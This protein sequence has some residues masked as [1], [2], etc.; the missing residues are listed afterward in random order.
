MRLFHAITSRVAPP[1]ALPLHLVQ[2]VMAAALL[3]T[4][5][6][7]LQLSWRWPLV[8]DATLFHYCILLLQRGFAPYRQI[9]DINLPGTYFAEWMVI[10]LFGYGALPWRIF[11]LLLL[12]VIAGATLAILPRTQG[13]REWFG[14]LWVGAIFALLHGRDG[15]TQMGQRD[16]LLTALLGG[17]Y[18]LLFRAFR[19]GERSRA[20]AAAAMGGAGLLLGAAATVK[21]LALLFVPALLLLLWRAQGAGKVGNKRGA[22]VGIRRER[23]VLAS[24][25]LLGAALPGLIALLFLVHYKAVGAF[26]TISRSLVPLHAS[27]FRWPLPHLLGESVSS[28][29]LPL[30]LL[31]LPAVWVSK[32]WKE[33]EGQALLLG[34]GLGVVSFCVQ[35]RGYPYHRYPSE[36]FL[37]LL[38]ARVLPLLRRPAAPAWLR[39]AALAPLLFGALVTAPRS[40]HAIA[41]FTPERDPLDAALTRSLLREGGRTPHELDGKVQCLDMAGGCVTTLLHRQLAQSTG[42]LYDCYA[43]VPV[44]PAFRA[45][46]KSYRAEWMRALE[47]N[48]PTLFIVTSDECGPRDDRYAKLGQWPELAQLLQQQY[49]LVEQWQPAAARGETQ[50]WGSWPDLPYGFRLY[51][52]VGADKYVSAGAPSAP[53]GGH[54]ERG[55]LAPARWPVRAQ[56]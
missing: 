51:R 32:P 18:A 29:M 1:G 4:V 43:F 41:Q 40:L 17:A 25:M 52:R 23:T 12:L 20:G 9:V 14:A 50:R 28:V 48:P 26:V 30:F 22:Q 7:Y 56:R 55:H 10:R 35:G 6:R 15:I 8:G 31:G 36:F 44:A 24:G 53:R 13:R 11:D 5:L 38:W 16:L 19:S 47:G 45:A 21:P 33:W 39:G 49:V 54:R 37:L 46:Q 2:G 42:Y 34:F 3:G 27:L